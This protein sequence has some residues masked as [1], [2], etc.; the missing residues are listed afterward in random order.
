VHGDGD[1]FNLDTSIYLRHGYSMKNTIYLYFLLFA[2]C[3]TIPSENDFYHRFS[4]KPSITECDLGNDV[5][6]KTISNP[7]EVPIVV[8][9][10]CDDE[11]VHRLI[12]VAGNSNTSF[13]SRSKISHGC[14]IFS[15]IVK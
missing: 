1:K 12:I 3:A 5:R 9:V 15:W 13:V 10:D 6:R 11:A 2:G 7:Y 14:S 8:T 4:A